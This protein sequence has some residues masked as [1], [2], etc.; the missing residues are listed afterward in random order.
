LPIL[1]PK[2]IN[3]KLVG[4]VLDYFGRRKVLMFS[5][6]NPDTHD[7]SLTTRP[8]HR[9]IGMGRV[10]PLTYHHDLTLVDGSAEYR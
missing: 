1:G 10:F 9:S 6:S 4:T 7:A 5:H 8:T 3:Q 2:K